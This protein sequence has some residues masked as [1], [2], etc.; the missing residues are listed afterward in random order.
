MRERS[1]GATVFRQVRP[2]A[3]GLPRAIRSRMEP[4]SQGTS[5]LLRQSRSQHRRRVH[6]RSRLRVDR[7]SSAGSE[8]ICGQQ[9]GGPKAGCSRRARSHCREEGDRHRLWSGSLDSNVAPPRRDICSG[10]RH[11]RVSA[12]SVAQFTPHVTRANIMAIPE[13]HPE[14]VGAFDFANF[15]GVAMCT[16]DPLRAFL[17]AAFTVRPGC[18]VPVCLRASRNSRDAVDQYAAQIL[19]Q[20]LVGRRAAPLSQSG[21]RAKVAVTDFARRQLEESGTKHPC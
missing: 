18:D 5:R 4:S 11:V 14:W 7:R 2:A 16:H 15:W 21:L 12:K 10:G 8:W 17:S 20:S 3:Y 19:S 13:E 9:H 6:R 1:S